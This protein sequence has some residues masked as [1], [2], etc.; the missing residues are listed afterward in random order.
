MPESDVVSWNAINAGYAQN[1]DGE[2]ALKLFA[3][4]C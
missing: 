2:N 4:C 3:K 1:G